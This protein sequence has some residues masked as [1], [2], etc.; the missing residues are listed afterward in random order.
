MQVLD[1]EAK[2][3]AFE[4]ADAATQQTDKGQQLTAELAAE[5][6]RAAA[7]EEEAGRLREA[8]AHAAAERHEAVEKIRGEVSR[9]WSCYNTSTALHCSIMR[10]QMVL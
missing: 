3:K 1:L 4:A 10:P 5:R 7:A 8:V 9:L 2:V 6:Q